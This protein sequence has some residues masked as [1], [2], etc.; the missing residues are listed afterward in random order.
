M[1]G[2]YPDGFVGEETVGKLVPPNPKGRFMV[3]NDYKMSV[4][5]STTSV[6]VSSVRIG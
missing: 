3:E 6:M 1:I 5:K 2:A 4:T